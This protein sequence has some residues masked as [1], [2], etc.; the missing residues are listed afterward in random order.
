MPQEDLNRLGWEC[1]G[2]EGIAPQEVLPSPLE[3]SPGI[4]GVPEEGG[5]EGRYTSDRGQGRKLPKSL[6]EAFADAE[7]ALAIMGTVTSSNTSDCTLR[8]KTRYGLQS[9]KIA[10]SVR[11]SGLTSIISATAQSDDVWNTGGKSAVERFYEALDN[12][13]NPD[14]APSRNGATPLRT[15]LAIAAFLLVLVG[16]LAVGQHDTDDSTEEVRVY[17]P[18]RFGWE[19]GMNLLNEAPRDGGAYTMVAFAQACRENNPTVR[20]YTV[21]EYKRFE[22]G[23]LQA[24]QSWKTHGVVPSPK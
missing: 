6:A 4:P 11:A 8:G 3:K 9:V 15:L 14:Y 5:C 12:S 24:Y 20:S 10:V 23:C 2:H 22:S 18:E 13:D 19:L 16:I 7:K 21:D 17:T 1:A